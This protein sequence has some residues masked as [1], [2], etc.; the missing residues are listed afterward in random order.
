MALVAISFTENG[1]YALFTKSIASVTIVEITEFCIC[2]FGSSPDVPSFLGR[3]AAAAGDSEA[4]AA[5]DWQAA[6]LAH[7]S[8]FVFCFQIFSEGYGGKKCVD[9]IVSVQAT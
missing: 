5:V 6:L 3:Q 4:E 1:S 2:E 8:W 7:H 9:G